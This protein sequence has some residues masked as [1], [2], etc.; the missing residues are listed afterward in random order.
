MRGAD[1]GK[2]PVS[3]S[4]RGFMLIRIGQLTP[5]RSEHALSPT[6]RRRGGGP[7]ESG[8]AL[9]DDASGGGSR[10]HERWCGKPRSG[11]CSKQSTAVLQYGRAERVRGSHP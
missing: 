2:A 7:S 9:R 10:E 3:I 8:G 6:R 5:T 1:R 4:H 11:G